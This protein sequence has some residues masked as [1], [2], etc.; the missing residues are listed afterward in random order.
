MKKLIATLIFVFVQLVAVCQDAAITIIVEDGPSKPLPDVTI[1]LLRN[2]DS[3]LIKAQLTDI[4]GRANFDN[5]TQ[6]NYLARVSFIGYKVKYINFQLSANNQHLVQGVNLERNIA[7]LSN[8]TITAVK[9]LVELKP[10]KTIVNLQSGITNTG[11]I[12]RPP[13]KP[14][15]PAI[16]PANTPSKAKLSHSM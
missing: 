3:V 6:T 15:K 2:N 16:K 7:Q 13:P 4:Y 10:G 1:E 5:L 9:P 14:S 8:V 11:T 12:T